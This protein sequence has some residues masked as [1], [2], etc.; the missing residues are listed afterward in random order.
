MRF[1]WSNKSDVRSENVDLIQ[2]TCNVELISMGF[3]PKLWNFPTRQIHSRR[4]DEHQV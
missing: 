4:T 2:N 3:S 1:Y